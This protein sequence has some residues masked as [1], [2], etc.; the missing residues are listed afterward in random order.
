M[1]YALY[2]SLHP[3]RGLY[4][5]DHHSSSTSRTQ[6]LDMLDRY[7]RGQSLRLDVYFDSEDEMPVFAIHEPSKVYEYLTGGRRCRR[8]LVPPSARP[9]SPSGSGWWA[10]ARVTHCPSWLA[11]LVPV[12]RDRC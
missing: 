3:D 12:G 7:D 5:A 11:R 10:W 1:Y 9:S 6:V 2:L 8:Y 4:A